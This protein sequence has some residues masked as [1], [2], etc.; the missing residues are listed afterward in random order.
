[1]PLYEYSCTFCK[2]N[3]EYRKKMSDSDPRCIHCGHPELE[4]ILSAPQLRFTGS[5]FYVTDY[6]KGQKQNEPR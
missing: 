3:F 4:Q 1:M 5:G 6:P 2:S